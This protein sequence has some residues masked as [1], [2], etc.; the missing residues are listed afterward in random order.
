ME[1]RDPTDHAWA[2]RRDGLIYLFTL[3]RLSSEGSIAIVKKIDFDYLKVFDS[4]SLPHTK[5]V[6]EKMCVCVCVCVCARVCVCVCAR[7]CVYVC[8][9]VA[10]RKA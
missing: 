4:I 10:E 5:K 2:T 6:F 9:I 1:G 3:E 7:A 8:V